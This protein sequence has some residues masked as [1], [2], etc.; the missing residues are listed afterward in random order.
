MLTLFG[1]T[2]WDSPSVFTAYVALREKG[3]EFEERALELRRGEQREAGFAGPSLTGKVPTIEHDGFWLSESLAIVEY[4]EERFPPP[5]HPPLWPQA[6]E[7]R[8]RARQLVFWL[9][10]DALGALRRER[11]AD[12]IFYTPPGAPLGERAAAQAAALV[13]IAERVLAPDAPHVAGPWSIADAE[14]A[15]ALM[16]MIRAGDPLPERLTR[17]AEGAWQRPSV[18]AF[19]DHDRPADPHQ[20]AR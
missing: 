5:A 10:S 18:R 14:L 11:P 17:W 2:L 15:F 1:E 12:G 19:V 3:V 13:R 16:R 9:R 4:L 6:I 7:Q 8:A 20:M